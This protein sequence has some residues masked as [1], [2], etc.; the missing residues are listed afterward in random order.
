MRRA[1]SVQC[2]AYPVYDVAMSENLNALLCLDSRMSSDM[3]ML[4]EDLSG[5][6]LR[7]P[8]GKPHLVAA[9]VLR[10]TVRA[11]LIGKS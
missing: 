2:N 9:D 8:I 6:G 3:I 10:L 11:T 7:S 5:A 1:H 4:H